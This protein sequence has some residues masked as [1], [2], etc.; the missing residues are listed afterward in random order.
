[1]AVESL[2]FYNSIDLVPICCTLATVLAPNITSTGDSKDSKAKEITQNGQRS[3]STY[4][5]PRG[6]E[7]K[8][9]SY[10]P[11]KANEKSPPPST[12]TAPE[13]IKTSRV[14][15]CPQPIRTNLEAI[16]LPPEA[17]KLLLVEGTPVVDNKQQAAPVTEDIDWDFL[18]FYEER[19][20]K[21]KEDR[22][23]GCKSS[24][25]LFFFGEGGERK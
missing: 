1:M 5:V 13:P 9:T 15:P 25:F 7:T 11:P 22:I 6:K 17:A 12:R 8:R 4:S 20:T 18:L 14:A 3:I 21:R 16:T 23:P 19:E 10:P 24:L 2:V